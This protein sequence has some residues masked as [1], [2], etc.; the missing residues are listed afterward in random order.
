MISPRDTDDQRILSC[1]SMRDYF[2]LIIK[3]LRVKLNLCFVKNWSIFHYVL[4][5]TWIYPKT[6]EKHLDKS[7]QV[8]AWLNTSGHAQPKV[9]L[10]CYLS[11]VTISM[12]KCKISFDF[13]QRYWWSKNFIWFDKSILAYT[14]WQEHFGLYLVNYNFPRNWTRTRK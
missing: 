5:P 11:T 10:N 1:D 8:W 7:R 9:S 2:D 6:N 3:T 12:Q 4:F 14:L 13:F